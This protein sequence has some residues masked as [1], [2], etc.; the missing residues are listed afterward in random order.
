M[1][2]TS[3][4][5]GRDNITFSPGL[6]MIPCYLVIVVGYLCSAIFGFSGSNETHL[7]LARV[8][9]VVYKVGLIIILSTIR[10]E[11]VTQK[12]AL[13]FV[14]DMTLSGNR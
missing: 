8:V 10:L 6:L 2:W 4:S 7:N 13:A 11:R 9:V 12:A 1:W 5:S 14:D 3:A